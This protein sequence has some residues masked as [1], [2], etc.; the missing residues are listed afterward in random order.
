[1]VCSQLAVPQSRLRGFWDCAFGILLP[2]DWGMLC[3]DLSLIVKL[4]VFKKKVHLFKSA[5]N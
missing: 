1:M 2:Q 5:F 3:Q 4:L